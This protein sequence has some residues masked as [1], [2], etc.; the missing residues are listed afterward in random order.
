MRH[1]CTG[2]G[3]VDGGRGVSGAGGAFAVSV[4]IVAMGKRM[5]NIRFASNS[6]PGVRDAEGRQ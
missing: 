5:P 1:K 6:A 4:G 2:V 3:N